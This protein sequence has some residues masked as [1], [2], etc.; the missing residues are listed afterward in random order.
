MR[1]GTGGRVMCAPRSA[2]LF[3]ADNDRT[4]NNSRQ[5]HYY[6]IEANQDLAGGLYAVTRFSRIRVTGGLPLVGQG[7]FATYYF[8]S[9]LTDD[10]HRLSFGLGYRFAPSLLWK[11][12]YNIEGGHLV[13]GEHRE[14]ENLL[15]T[16][17]ALEF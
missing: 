14:E 5:A 16:E 10:L 3:L 4:A 7:D 8:H 2:R 6:Y 13:S 1:P 12:E 9:A 15:S 17:I 11:A